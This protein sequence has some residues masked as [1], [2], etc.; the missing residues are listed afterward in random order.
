MYQHPNSVPAKPRIRGALS[1]A[2][3]ELAWV[4]SRYDIH[5]PLCYSAAG[6]YS[7]P[8]NPI[9]EAELKK[10]VRS[11]VVAGGPLTRVA[12]RRVGKGA[13]R[14]VCIHVVRQINARE[15]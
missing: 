3:F 1:P 5:Y 2:A 14:A 11:V 7:E 10:L 13:L 6:P 4:F 8:C 15:G 12:G 9:G